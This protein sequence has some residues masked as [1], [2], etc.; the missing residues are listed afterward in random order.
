MAVSKLVCVAVYLQR[1]GSNVARITLLPGGV[2][3]RVRGRGQVPSSSGGMLS[4]RSPDEWWNPSR[5]PVR[6]P[7]RAPRDIYL[8]VVVVG[9]RPRA[10][11]VKAR[12]A[13]DKAERSQVLAV[14]K[15]KP[16]KCTC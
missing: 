1:R 6:D 2:Y 16:R 9:G 14:A 15:G 12:G 5:V 8:A 3:I 4:L 10:A 13:D 7:R 11:A